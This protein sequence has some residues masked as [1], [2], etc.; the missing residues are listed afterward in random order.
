MLDQ[1]EEDEE[2]DYIINGDL[3]ARIG[4]WGLS[5]GESEI[6]GEDDDE[7][8][9]TRTSQ[10][11]IVNDNGHKL[12]Q[13][14]TAFNTTSL[15]GI[16]YKRFD[17]NFTFI[18]RRGCSTIDHFICSVGLLD[19]VVEYRT[20]NR[21]ES[22]HMPIE[23]TLVSSNQR[24]TEERREEETRE[25]SKTRW[26]EAKK[27]E[28]AN[29]L[30][31]PR[32]IRALEEATEALDI[33]VDEGVEN[34]DKVMKEVNKPMNSTLKI[35]G[36]NEPKKK[37]FD[38]ECETKK[39]Q[40]RQAL[41]NL[42]KINAK[43]K[44]EEYKLAKDS[45]LDKRIS[46]QKLV[47][48]KRKQYKREMQEK[49][50][51]A[52]HD[53]KTFWGE[54]RKISFKKSKLVNISIEQWEDHFKQVFNPQGAVEE[55][56]E[57]EGQRGVDLEEGR[58]R[59]EEEVQGLGNRGNRDIEE[60]EGEIELD[61]EITREEIIS[62]IDKLKKGKAGG[63]DDISAE[64]IQLS[65]GRI[66]EFLFKLFNKMFLISYFPIKWAVAIVVPLHKKGDINE[67][68]NYRGISLLS[69]T[70]KIFTG[71]LNKRLYRW[72]EENEKINIEPAGFRKKPFYYRPYFYIA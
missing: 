26:R 67:P 35:G 27:E 54:I 58:E 63:I 7:E 64:L 47:R 41:V 31:K 16:K 14:C 9:I 60:E 10:D 1:L 42:N 61:E 66:L 36:Q 3:N 11:G 15:S 68:D 25:I 17:D 53:A 44:K 5:V 13:I 46:Y 20:M 23:M 59:E 6:G 72:S 2:Y 4:D 28:S 38:K 37:W 69:I 32:T 43:K 51:N 52:R 49:L 24:A 56:G 62:G 55:E 30:N 22:Q 57:E 71:I 19:N 50:V 8:E 48:E 29:I 70:S 45:Y 34:F 65:K 12:V 18:G 39:K 21:V 40:A 33:S